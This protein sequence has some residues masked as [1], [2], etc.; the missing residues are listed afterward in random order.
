MSDDANM[1]T[2][3]G[4]AHFERSVSL[5]GI[6]LGPDQPP[7][8]RHS[9]DMEYFAG[10]FICPSTENND[11]VALIGTDRGLVSL[12][13]PMGLRYITPISGRNSSSYT[14]RFRD[15]FA[16]DYQVNHHSTFF[17]GGRPGQFHKGDLR[18]APMSWDSMTLPNSIAH[19]KSVSDYQVLVAGLNN[20][21]SIFDLRYCRYSPASD[22]NPY[23]K[24]LPLLNI[25][26]YKNMAHFTL[27]FDF[28]KDTGVVAAAHDDGKVALYSVRDGRRLPSPVIDAIH[29]GYGP[30]HCIQMQALPGDNMPRLFMGE[31]NQIKVY[32][33][34]ASK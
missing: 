20:M 23:H 14:T 29:S 19:I 8:Q 21:L 24:A 1:T 6:Q 33:V 15:I 32:S 31:D 9:R 26:G 30:I 5:A 17:M 28:D 27:G 12:T 18:E 3:I 34:D 2:N 22:D 4:E 10:Y 7:V 11:T 16:I 25:P 13:E